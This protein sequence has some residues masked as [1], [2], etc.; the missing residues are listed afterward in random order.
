[1]HRHQIQDK[2]SFFRL[3]FPYR[4]NSKYLLCNLFQNAK[5]ESENYWNLRILL[6]ADQTMVEHYFD[7]NLSLYLTTLFKEVANI[8]RYGIAIIKSAPFFI[9]LKMLS[10]NFEKKWT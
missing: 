2:L 5:N 6:V 4:V 9:S 8:F 7:E 3:N 1:M 10:H